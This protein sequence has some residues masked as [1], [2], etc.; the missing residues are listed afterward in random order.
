MFQ[1]RCRRRD[2]RRD[3]RKFHR[4]FHMWVQERRSLRSTG[5]LTNAPAG[6]YRKVRKHRAAI[7][8][9]DLRLID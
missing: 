8:K 7:G 2:Q 6:S 1:G 9:A 5:L 4:R 3:H